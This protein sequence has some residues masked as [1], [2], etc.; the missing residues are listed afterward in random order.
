MGG[1]CMS[2]LL[3]IRGLSCGYGDRPVLDGVDLTVR[4]GEAVLLAGP[5]GCGKSTLLKA[6]IGV[7]PLIGDV[8]FNGVS[9]VGQFVEERVRAHIGFRRQMNNYFPVQGV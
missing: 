5:N 8:M 2:D 6:I 3:E 9:L 4:E 7:L 1:A